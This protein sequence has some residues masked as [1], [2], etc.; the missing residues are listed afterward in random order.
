MRH[1]HLFLFLQF[2]GLVPGHGPSHLHTVAFDVICVSFVSARSHVASR[3]RHICHLLLQNLFFFRVT[4]EANKGPVY[5]L[6]SP[7]IRLRPAWFLP[8]MG[9]VSILLTDVL[10]RYQPNLTLLRAYQ[11][12]KDDL[13]SDGLHFSAL[14]G[15]DYVTFLLD[16][17]Q[18]VL[19]HILILALMYKLPD[20]L[21]FYF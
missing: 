20:K 15:R 11:S 6:A 17:A 16:Q 10:H 5:F 9:R 12:S 7:T 13:D 4:A 1:D 14:A 21:G 3:W 8:A 18:Y 2:I 19:L